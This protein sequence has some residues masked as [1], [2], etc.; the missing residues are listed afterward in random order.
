[1]TIISSSNSS[2]SSEISSNSSSETGTDVQLPDSVAISATLA[3]LMAFTLFDNLLVLVAFYAQPC[4]RKVIYYPILSLALADLLCAVTAMPLYIIMSNTS[5]V[6]GRIICDIYRFFYF[7]TEY[8][9]ILS[10]MVISIERFLVIYHPLT[11]R[12]F[13]SPRFMTT[14]LVVCWLEALVVS[15]MPFYWRSEKRSKNCTNSPT[16]DWSIMVISVNVFTPFL[17]MLVCHCYI[18]HKTLK[19]FSNDESAEVQ[20]RCLANA[21]TREQNAKIERKATISFAVIIGLFVIC[22]GPS[23]LYYFIQNICSDCLSESFKPWGGKMSAS[24]K[25]MTFANSFMNLIIYF[26]LNMDF[27]EAFVRVLRRKWASKAVFKSKSRSTSTSNSLNLITGNA[28][29]HV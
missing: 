10:L 27:R 3:I 18:Y 11:F 25:I 9:S 2:V 1:M 20:R 12:G 8:S 14:G 7:F 6:D 13:I 15:T 26:W 19:E 24:V 21:A 23:T 16:N 22:W 29:T 17:V 4:L 5:D 28:I